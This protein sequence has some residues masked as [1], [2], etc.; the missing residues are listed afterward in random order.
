MA[1]LW[2]EGLT[3]SSDGQFFPSGSRGDALNLVN[4]RYGSEPGTKLYTHVSDQYA[5]F[6]VNQITATAFEAP[7]VLDGLMS[8]DAGRRVREHFTDTGGFTDHLFATAA[9]LGF[10][11]AP[12]IRNLPDKRLY[13]GFFYS[14]VRKA[15]RSEAAVRA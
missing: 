15:T 10:A 6:H 3:S 8:T 11:F 14:K 13:V 1:R 12:R 5:P 9:I 7:Y 4:A 2:G